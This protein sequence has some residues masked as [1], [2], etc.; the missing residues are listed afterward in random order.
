VSVVVWVSG[1]N[2]AAVARVA[3]ALAERL[4]R[5]VAT[6]LV[7]A[8]APDLQGIAG[9]EVER[10]AAFA[11]GRLLPH[12]IATIVAVPSPDR[13]ARAAIRAQLGR[14]IEVYVAVAVARA[15]YEPSERP[16]VQVDLPDSELASACDRTLR[17]LELLGFLPRADDA[18]YSAEEERQV[19]RRLKSFGYL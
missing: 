2:D 3:D 5:R 7:D 17:T 15:D 10:C 4:R 12:G 18:A 19:I 8:R 14:M 6:E 1:P 9:P 11:A 16:E 13:R